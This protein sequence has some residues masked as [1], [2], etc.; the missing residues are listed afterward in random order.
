MQSTTLTTPTTPFVVARDQIPLA[1]NSQEPTLK[2]RPF[3]GHELMAS[4]AHPGAQLSWL[5]ARAGQE[6]P[7]R[8][9]AAPS[10]LLIMRGRATLVGSEARAVEQG[11]VLTLPSG[12]AYGFGQ[13][14]AD[15]HVLHVALPVQAAT[16]GQDDVLSLER[17]LERHRQRARQ[18]LDSPGY[19]ALRNGSF[20]TTHRREAVCQAI[21]VFSDAFQTFLFTRQAMCRDQA[22]VSMFHGHLLE[23]LGHNDLL[24]VEGRERIL[25]DPILRAASSWF[26]H[27]MLTLDNAGKTVVNL[28]LETSGYHFHNLAKPVFVDIDCGNYFEAH[29]EADET[30]MELGIDLLANQH[31]DVYRQL[32][33][34]L[35]DSWDMLET[36]TNRFAELAE[37][38]PEQAP[39]AAQ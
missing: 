22:Y 39:C 23:E 12:Q 29:A 6:V 19:T 20:N 15:L 35:E 13:I 38:E 28:V 25:R 9:H 21:R 30:H 10:L 3:V 33:R 31:P 1:A 34:I 14:E 8:S 5:E 4:V 24:K 37:L 7:I 36:V 27:R 11:D 2:T 17:L 18:I 16:H 32:L 26:S